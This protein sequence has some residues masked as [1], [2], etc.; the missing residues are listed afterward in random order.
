MRAAVLEDLEKLVVKEVP[1]PRIDDYSL[2]VKVGACAICGSDIR[3]F[4]HGNNRLTPPAIM[5]HE[6]SGEI[7]E[8][9][10]RV[11]GFQAGD[12]V[13]LGGDV[14]CGKC[15]MCLK[16]LGNN[17]PINYAMGYQFAG[18]FAEYVLLNPLVVEHG[19][20]AKVP[21][22]VS[23][24]EAALAEPLACCL[25]GIELCRPELGDT[26]VVVGAGPLGILLTE[27][28][29]LMGVTK[30]LVVNR[31]R[32]R[33]EIAKTFGVDVTICSSEENTVERVLE[34]THG[35]G[36]NIIITACPSP[37]AQAET[38]HYAAHRARI[39]LFGGLPKGKSLVPID[40]NVLHYREIFLFGSHGAVPSHLKKAIDLIASGKIDMKKYISHTFP[41]ESALEAFKAAEDKVGMRVVL[42]P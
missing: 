4:H 24:E 21:D 19:P 18:S 38:L 8:V 37:E 28:G 36:A 33:L 9:G 30:T 34:E 2:L 14:P 10:S 13:A 27:L 31:S 15:E 16:G 41:L 17:C 20:I 5:G 22:H 12:R 6:A 32:P 39:N 40:T 26:M 11:Q 29:K 35:E 25:N 42:K 1:K 23:F 7:V 3:M